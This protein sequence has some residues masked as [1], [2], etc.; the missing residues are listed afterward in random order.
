MTACEGDGLILRLERTLPA[1]CPVVY[2]TLTDPAELGEWWGPRGFIA[3]SVE[4]D[5][6]VGGGYRIAMQPPDGDAF[7]LAGEFRQVEPPTR[8]AYTFRWDPPH[9]DDR[10]TSVTLTLESSG[11]ETRLRL[12]QRGFATQERLVLH[13]TGWSETLDRL[14]CRVKRLES[15]STLIG[16][17]ETRGRGSK[18]PTRN[19]ED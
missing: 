5:L 8:L 16:G 9:P 14:A 3:R 18:L 2:S 1:P 6:Q 12:T 10:E 19:A 11:E 15:Q 4:F 7:H 17:R 13:R